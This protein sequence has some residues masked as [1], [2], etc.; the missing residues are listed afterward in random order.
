MEKET[1]V[2]IWK[3]NTAIRRMVRPE[4]GIVRIAVDDDFLEGLVAECPDSYLAV[5]D[6][7]KKD[8]Y[9]QVGY[10]V[11]GGGAYGIACSRMVD[12]GVRVTYMVVQERDGMLLI[13]N[14][15]TSVCESPIEEVDGWHNVKK[16]GRRK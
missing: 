14:H 5:L 6:E 15:E 9:N 1:Y 16:D 3:A 8:L 7:L 12:G 2:L 11:L 13:K 4:G 10:S